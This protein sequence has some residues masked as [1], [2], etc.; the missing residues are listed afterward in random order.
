MYQNRLTKWGFDKNNKETEI[1]A[2][3]RKSSERRAVNKASAFELRGRPVNLADVERYVKR[4]GWLVEDIVSEEVSIPPALTCLTPTTV[5]RPPATPVRLAT[6]VHIFA[7]IRDY[8][9]GSFE[10]GTWTSG[11][12]SS[13]C[14]STKPKGS[15]MMALKNLFSHHEVA[16]KLL[17]NG[18][19]DEAGRE[20]GNA[21]IGIKEILLTE[22]PRT[23]ASLF[24]LIMLLRGRRRP[25]IARVVVNQF[26][27][28]AS[29]VLPKMH[30]LSQVCKL[31]TSL[32]A[33]QFELVA[34]TAWQS[35]VDQ[36]EKILGAMH[37][38]TLRC[39]LEYIQMAESIYGYERA[40]MMLRNL[41][42][43][44]E[45][46]CSPC[47]VRLLKLL[48]TLAETLLEQEKFAEAESMARHIV[49]RAPG[50]KPHSKS[51]DLLCAGLFVIARVQRKSLR[52]DMAE[53]TLRKA[54]ALNVT[55]WGWQHALTL[56]YLV[57]LEEWLI[58]SDQFVTAD[59]VR[60][61]R[62]TI[63]ESI[64]GNSTT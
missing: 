9:A 16:C 37:Y 56:K 8:F 19:F 28:L 63:L 2:I 40:E 1:R 51:V 31:L 42:S 20:L 29:I 47:D 60:L 24:D 52:V 3:V 44:C 30:P 34:I 25:E 17:D 59:S 26:S 55:Q 33:T 49:I 7:N 45:S 43:Q 21:S 57:H 46:I 4:K 15:E 62:L 5:P 35:A 53:T 11:D 50:T 41:V 64:E 13:D 36:F 27:A 54:I 22:H 18:L 6:P 38:S 61:D 10:A 12:A 48:D 39:R 58:D 32:D 23:L 14:V